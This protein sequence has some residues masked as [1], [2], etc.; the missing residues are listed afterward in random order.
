M[1]GLM[2]SCICSAL[3]RSIIAVATPAI[4]AQFNSVGDV[5]WYGSAYL[6]TMCA[7]Q[8]PMGKLF[9]ELDMKYV[10][11]ITMA[12]FEIGSV[13]CAAA[14]SSTVLIVGRAIAGVGGAGI[15][16]G[17]LIVVGTATSVTQRPGYLALLG[18]TI[19]LGQ[20]FG[21]LIGG[22][23]VERASWRWCFLIN[24]PCGAVTAVLLITSLQLPP[25]ASRPRGSSWIHSFALLLDLLDAQSA[26]I[27][28]PS[29]VSLLLALQ[30]GGSVEPWSSWKCILLLC[31]FGITFLCWVYMQYRRADRATVP[32]RILKQR[33]VA[34]GSFYSMTAFGASMVM[35]YYLPI[36]F[37]AVRGVSALEAG[38]D[39]SPLMV[40]WAVL[41]IVSAQVTART[42][43]VTA[44]MVMA[45]VLMSV[46][47]GL[48]TRYDLQTSKAYWVT[49]LF[50]YGC[51]VGLGVQ[52]PI[53]AAMALLKGKDVAL[54]SSLI[55]FLQVMSGTIMVSVG[56]NLFTQRLGSSLAA[57]APGVSLDVVLSAGN[58]EI[59]QKMGRIYGPEQV[60]GILTAYNESIVYVFF[61]AMIL[62]CLTII[63]SVGMEWR[64]INKV[65]VYEGGTHTSEEELR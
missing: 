39:L 1:A 33:S 14:P 56:Q 37:Q 26:A 42:G 24:L 18:A 64:N 31:I 20:A 45:S 65:Q 9:A 29:I 7:F 35:L 57:S 28:I 10:Y 61:F 30:W 12:I 4:T 32:P 11:L 13:I 44:Q 8:L 60:A 22:A 2:L 46:M 38:I 49:T 19:N 50:F 62:A 25:R 47:L 58:E 53:L 54:G 59:A 23:L 6:L 5:G 40:A 41:L 34:F 3:D 63:G 48:I 27:L 17:A 55:M 15:V 43:Y 21:P 51:G 16:A 36:W 52:L